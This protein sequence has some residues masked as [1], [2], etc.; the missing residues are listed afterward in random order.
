LVL[1][2]GTPYIWM[3]QPLSAI[4]TPFRV[5]IGG[6]HFFGNCIWDALGI[7]AM[8]GG[9]GT[10]TA[11]CPDCHEQMSVTVA[12]NRLASGE[13]VVHFALPAARWWDD[14]GFT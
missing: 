11:W 1:A 14:I 8:M 2:P 3:A 12:Q 5:E 13:G 10:V 6:R 7:V 9:T 4:P